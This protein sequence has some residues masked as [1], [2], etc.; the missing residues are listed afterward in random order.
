MLQLFRYMRSSYSTRRTHIPQWAHLDF[1]LAKRIIMREW[2]TTTIPQ[3]K[4]WEKKLQ[5]E[6]LGVT[7]KGPKV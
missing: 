6:A 3:Q 7:E 5:G 2:I 1:L 4:T